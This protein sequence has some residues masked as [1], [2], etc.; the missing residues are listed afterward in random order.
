MAE[1]QWEW[2]ADRDRLV[3]IAGAAIF[4][5]AI[6]LL[7]TIYLILVA[8]RKPGE[9]GLHLSKLD[10]IYSDILLGALIIILF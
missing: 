10:R 8:G 5:L 2:Q 6:G 4:C 1:K 9:A 3:P 7:L